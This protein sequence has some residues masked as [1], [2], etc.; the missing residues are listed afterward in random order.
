MSALQ[1]QIIQSLNG[2][3]DDN[4]QFILDMIQKFMKPVNTEN[5]VDSKTNIRKIGIF[6]HEDLYDKDYDFDEF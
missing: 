3:S 5:T 2:L 6:E 1:S 4:L